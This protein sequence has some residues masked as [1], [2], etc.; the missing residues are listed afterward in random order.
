M[1]M[2]EEID[3][4]KEIKGGGRRQEGRGRKEIKGIEGKKEMKRGEKGEE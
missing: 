3:G 2:R 1:E 4:H